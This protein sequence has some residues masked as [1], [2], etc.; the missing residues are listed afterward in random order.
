MMFRHVSLKEDFMSKQ[1][2]AQR[3]KNITGVV[4]EYGNRLFR[5]IRNR[6][7][8]NADA[9]DI[10]QEVWFQFSNVVDIES[11]NQVSGWLFKVAR[12]KV[13]DSFRKKKLELIED[14]SYEN[15]AGDLYLKDILLAD[16]PSPEDEN[17]RQIFWEQLFIALDE[18]PEKQR[19]VFMQN[20]MEDRTFQEIAE[21][22]GE[23]I[24]TLISRKR[25]AI[26]HLRSRLNFLYEE[27]L[28][29]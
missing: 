16:F 27:F 7:A 18:L 10:L 13:T 20:E 11:I 6:V 23:N 28:N 26:Q 12:N 14:F 5:F 3:E 19:F 21:E 8:T 25:Y 29:D 4:K 2:A 24:K 1:M 9:E 17:L 22:T 15:E